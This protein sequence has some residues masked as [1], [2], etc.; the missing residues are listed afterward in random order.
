MEEDRKETRR[1]SFKNK[2]QKTHKHGS[3]EAKDQLKL[4]KAFKSRKREIEEEE[5]WEMWEDEIYR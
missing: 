4:N 1:A 2:K 5:I 3:A